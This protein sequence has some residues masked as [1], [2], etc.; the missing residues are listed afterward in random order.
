MSCK[1]CKQYFTVLW[2]PP[3]G[4]KIFPSC[5]MTEYREHWSHRLRMFQ[6]DVPLG[7]ILDPTWRCPHCRAAIGDCNKYAFDT[8]G[9]RYAYSAYIRKHGTPAEKKKRAK[10][11]KE[12]EKRSERRKRQLKERNERFHETRK[13]S[14]GSSSSRRTS[15][16]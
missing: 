15:S 7:S 10:E 11:D 5:C 14:E 2:K 3:C 6:K 9:A 16:Q 1:T 8:S 12:I 4:C 13:S